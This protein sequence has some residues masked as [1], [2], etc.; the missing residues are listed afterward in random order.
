MPPA[1]SCIR[2][3]LPVLPLAALLVVGGYYSARLSVDGPLGMSGAG[4]AGV[5]LAAAQATNGASLASRQ[6]HYSN[7]LGST[8]TLAAA[9]ALEGVGNLFDYAGQLRLAA[10]GG[11]AQAAWTLSRVYDY[12]ALY[13]QDPQGYRLDDQVLAGLQLEAAPGLVAAR[14]RVGQRCQGFARGDQLGRA[15]LL[16]RRQQAARSGNLAAEAAL[17]AM[18]E[19]L[20]T[21]ADY[22]RSLVERVIQAQDPEAFLALSPAMGAVAAGDQALYGQVAGSQFTQL[23]WQVAACRL[24]LA[25]GP[26][27][28]LMTTYCANGG[29]CSRKPEQ[30]FEAFVFDAA[31]AQ[32]G[33]EKMNELVNYLR[34]PPEA[35]Q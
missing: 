19:P 2:R 29:I 20:D 1:L 32:Q 9:T 14:Q 8:A 15:Q 13:A 24:G 18:G 31:I 3:F 21:G 4:A 5:P 35:G 12:C 7:A 17:L 25:C 28:V 26:D 6:D 11:D 22:R 27:S 10:D 33:G 34:R 30:G 23:A 16:Q